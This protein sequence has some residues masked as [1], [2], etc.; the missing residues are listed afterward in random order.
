M[1]VSAI[2]VGVP[3]PCPWLYEKRVSDLERR[4]EGET[5]SQGLEVKLL[6]RDFRFPRA[7]ETMKPTRVMMTPF[8]NALMRW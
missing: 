3:L 5:V 6:M 1:L 7:T 2:V 4:A 8:S